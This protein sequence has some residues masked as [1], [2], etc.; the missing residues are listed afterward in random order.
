VAGRFAAQLLS[1]CQD[2]DYQVRIAA[3]QQLPALAAALGAPAAVGQLLPELA[4]LLG[5][6]EV[7]VGTC[8]A[9]VCVCVSVCVCVGGGGGEEC[10]PRLCCRTRW[11][12]RRRL[13]ARVLP[14][15]L[16]LPCHRATRRDATHRAQVRMA[17]LAGLVALCEQLPREARVAQL[18]PLVRRHLQP[19]ELEPPV[20]RTLA[21]V[22]PRLLAAVS[23]GAWRA[24]SRAAA[25]LLWRTRRHA[26]HTCAVAVCHPAEKAHAA[27]THT[28]ACWR[29]SCAAQVATDLEP[30]DAGLVYSCFRCL[31]AR[32]CGC[33]HACMHACA[34]T[35][36]RRVQAC[37]CCR[38]A[39][40]P[41]AWRRRAVLTHRVCR[42]LAARSDVE[43][44]RVCALRVCELMRAPL[45]GSS[46]SYLHDTWTDLATDPDEQVC[47]VCVCVCLCVCVRGEWW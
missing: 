47:C 17:A 14:H 11:S 12:V 26:P 28:A 20:Q 1:A 16:L 24:L 32:V 40:D 34:C 27:S 35:C 2:T 39:P 31:E 9:C 38:A 6:D 22:F 18:L 41:A 36:T 15:V 46:P 30:S 8:G 13:D 37:C 29:P 3:A 23:G 44:R 33:M 5:D 45:P 21:D 42:H 19:L 4:E 7:Q 25:A 43:L 10:R